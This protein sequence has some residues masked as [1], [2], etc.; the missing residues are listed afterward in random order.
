MSC[1][2]EKLG[3]GVFLATRPDPGYRHSESRFEEN[4]DVCYQQP[5]RRLSRSAGKPLDAAPCEALAALPANRHWVICRTAVRR[6]DADALRIEPARA[7]VV[8]H[9]QPDVPPICVPVVVPVR[10]ADR[11]SIGK[12]ECAGFCVLRVIYPHWQSR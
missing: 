9:V 12:C 2:H 4:C 3:R 10:P 6:A 8:Y 7:T 11:L 1:S 5:A